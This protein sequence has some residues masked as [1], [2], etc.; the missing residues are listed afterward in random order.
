MVALR[1]VMIGIC[2]VILYQL[3]ELVSGVGVGGG[4]GG[5]TGGSGN[6]KDTPGKLYNPHKTQAGGR[7]SFS[8][9]STLLFF[10]IYSIL[11]VDHVGTCHRGISRLPKNTAVSIWATNLKPDDPWPMCETC[12]ETEFGGWPQG[13][14]TRPPS[15]PSP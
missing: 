9:S 3:Y 12:Q 10:L 15:P 5:T 2:I 4:I 14:Q 13:M 1:T 6:C 11:C 8:F 7:S